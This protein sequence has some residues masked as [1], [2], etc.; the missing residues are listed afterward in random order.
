MKIKTLATVLAAVLV[1]TGISI[2]VVEGLAADGVASSK[3][4]AA[5]KID[6]Q[7]ALKAIA[8][9]QSELLIARKA[10]GDQ[11]YESVSI[12]SNLVIASAIGFASLLIAVI[13]GFI[14]FSQKRMTGPLAKLGQTMA[15]LADGDYEIVVPF[16]GRADEIGAMAS[17]VEVFR[18]NAIERRRA[19]LELQES[20]KRIRTLVD[21]MSDGIIT[22]DL[23]GIVRSANPAVLVQFG[24]E[25]TEIIGQKV[26]VL[27]PEEFARDHDTYISNHLQT[28]V[29]KAIGTQREVTGRRKDG[30]TF[31]LEL[32]VS[33][34]VVHGEQTFTGHVRDITMRKNAEAGRA[35]LERAL[36]RERELSQAQKLEALGTLAGGIAHEINTPVQFVSDNTRFLKSAFVDLSAVL[37]KHRNLLQAATADN[38]LDDAVAE[39][40]AAVEAADMVS[41]AEDIPA[42]IHQSLE[43]LEQIAEIVKAIKEF[44]FPN[45]DEKNPADLNRAI[46]TT[47]TVCRNQWKYAAEL[48]TDLDTTLPLVPCLLG[49]F[50]QVVLNLI[51]NAAH[52]I[53]DSGN[54]S[55][56]RITVSTRRIEGWA[57]ICIGDTGTGIPKEIHDKIFEPFFTTKEP[58]RG[59]GQGLA[60]SRTIITK[61]HGGT[62]TFR[63]KVGEGTEFIIRLPLVDP[64]LSE[65]AA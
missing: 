20:E 7:A 5:V 41:L 42:A 29:P 27:M 47:I 24:Y 65:V 55:K 26:N 1:C 36:S 51:V 31:L 38:V 10:S 2:G 56:G 18:N 39:A 30:S 60:I 8:D 15:A 19:K 28:K 3:I 62:F 44:S 63:S 16:I 21:T 37:E 58:G 11:V 46:T 48:E 52:A 54:E 35:E 9:L 22:I 23:A 33:E 53:E 64:D 12:T 4:D 34:M 43:G 50:N 40:S 45:T 13:V 59:T 6:D 57:E 61:K 17:A 32:S 14:S 25:L 49:E